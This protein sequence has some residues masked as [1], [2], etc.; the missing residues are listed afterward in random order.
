VDDFISCVDDA[1][2]I[3]NL[4]VLEGCDPAFEAILKCAQPQCGED[5]NP[6]G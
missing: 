1:D 5:E 2:D 4:A 3:C 6:P